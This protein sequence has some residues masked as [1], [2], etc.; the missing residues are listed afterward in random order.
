[1][2]DLVGQCRNHSLGE[3]LTAVLL[4][5]TQMNDDCPL[6]GDAEDEVSGYLIA[7]GDR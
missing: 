3:A 4:P 1:V 2:S 5:D 6:H 7:V